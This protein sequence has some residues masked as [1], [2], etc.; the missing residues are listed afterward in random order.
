MER[1]PQHSRTHGPAELH[2]GIVLRGVT[3]GAYPSSQPQV[4]IPKQEAVPL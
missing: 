2:L 3:G 1:E 4:Q